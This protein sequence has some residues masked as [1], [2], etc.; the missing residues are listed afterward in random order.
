MDTDNPPARQ[1]PSGTGSD[2]RPRQ[3]APAA[4]TAR[5]GHDADACASLLARV[6]F[7][8]LMAGQ[9]WWID[10]DRFQCDPSYAARLLRLA[11]ASESLALRE[12]A[13]C[14]QMQMSMQPGGADPDS[15]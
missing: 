14:V 1:S 5:C 4:G 9:G 7:K 15:C 2:A 6:D 12:S 3:A 11:L 13:A 10:P 8:W